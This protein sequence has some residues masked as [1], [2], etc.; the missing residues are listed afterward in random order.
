M[1][2]SDAHVAVR[3]RNHQHAPPRSDALV[4]FGATGDLAFKK[5]FPALYHLALA[6]EL[7]RRIPP[8][9]PA[10]IS[11]TWHPTAFVV[12]GP[13]P[14]GWQPRGVADRFRQVFGRPL[15]VHS[16]RLT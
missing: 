16:T 10:V 5:L 14:T 8:S 11:C 1:S 3:G 15:H 6:D 12:R 2:T 4:F 7:K 13:L 9:Q